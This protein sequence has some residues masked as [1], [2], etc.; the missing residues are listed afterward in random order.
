MRILRKSAFLER[1][2]FTRITANEMMPISRCLNA[3]FR[4]RTAWYLSA[5][6]LWSLTLPHRCLP[7]AAGI[8][9]CPSFVPKNR[10]LAT[11]SDDELVK[12]LRNNRFPAIH[13][14]LIQCCRWVCRADGNQG[15]HIK[16][17]H[18]G[19][20]LIPLRL[21]VPSASAVMAGACIVV[22]CDD[23]KHKC[24]DLRKKQRR[25]GKPCRFMIT[26]L[27]HGFEAAVMNDRIIHSNGGLVYMDAPIWMQVGL[28]TGPIVQISASES[29]QD[30]CNPHERRP[31]ADQFTNEELA[32]SAFHPM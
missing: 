4:L 8:C 19:S 3:R 5:P 28:P 9:Q 14:S 24:D 7:W 11:T 2:A 25:T 1:T 17:M 10:Q 12:L 18:T 20:F 29:S 30:V 13:F 15:I 23:R 31:G 16:R 27:N 32:L 22:E 26:T 6:A 21:T